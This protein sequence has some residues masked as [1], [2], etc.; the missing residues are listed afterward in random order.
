MSKEFCLGLVL[1]MLAGALLVNNSQKAR[2]LVREGQEKV[3][4]K[5]KNCKRDEQSEE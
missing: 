3:M 1:G 4:D 5:I 2:K